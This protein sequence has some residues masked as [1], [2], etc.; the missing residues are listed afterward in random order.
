MN[1]FASKIIVVDNT[2]AEKLSQQGQ[3]NTAKKIHIW[4]RI[5]KTQSLLH[6]KPPSGLWGILQESEIQR[7]HSARWRGASRS[8]PDHQKDNPELWSWITSSVICKA[9]ELQYHQCWQQGSKPHGYKWAIDIEEGRSLSGTPSV[10]VTYKGCIGLWSPKTLTS[11]IW[12]WCFGLQVNSQKEV[13]RED[14]TF[15]WCFCQLCSSLR[16]L[17]L[18]HFSSSGALGGTCYEITVGRNRTPWMFFQ[19][20]LFS[21]KKEPKNFRWE[22][23]LIFRTIFIS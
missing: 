14:Q 1:S 13:K 10:M 16:Y 2:A 8:G 17:C 4:V 6:S 12:A 23:F 9:I 5:P 15:L 7:T 18:L 3:V 19:R 21:I 22:S 20:P 11:W